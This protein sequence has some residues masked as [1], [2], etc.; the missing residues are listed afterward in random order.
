[1]KS[2]IFQ[3][4]IIEL[5]KINDRAGNLSF[6]ENSKNIPFDIKRVYYIYDVPGG[7]DRGG[8][9]HKNL[10]QFVIAVS[11]AFEVSLDD[12]TNKKIVRLDRPFMAL[13]IQK[14]IW[15]ETRNFTSGSVCMVIASEDYNDEDYI[16]DYNEFLKFRIG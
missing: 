15:R 14:G 8:H 1:M 6:V 13:H 3:C 11:G 4:N 9:A 5:S 7:S 12:G 16:Y 2:S 10:E